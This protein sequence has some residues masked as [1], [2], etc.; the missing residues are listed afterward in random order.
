MNEE[1]HSL[2]FPVMYQQITLTEADTDSI[3]SIMKVGMN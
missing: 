3:R 2:V 1:L